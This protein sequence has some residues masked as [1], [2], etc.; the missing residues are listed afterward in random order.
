MSQRYQALGYANDLQKQMEEFKDREKRKYNEMS[1]KERMLN[2]QPLKAYETME[3]DPHSKILM[4][5]STHEERDN[6][7]RFN[8]RPLR[9]LLQ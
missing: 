9:S 7:R 6:Y 3:L 1:E 5:Y 2:Q 8:K 4:G